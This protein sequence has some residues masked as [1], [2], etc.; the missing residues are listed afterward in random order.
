[1]AK[2]S[3]KI[4]EVVKKY[5]KNAKDTGKTDVQIAILT[6]KI[7]ELSGHVQSHLKDHHSRKGL[8]GM[9]TRRRRLLKYLQ[10]RDVE[11]YRVLIKELDIRR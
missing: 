6:E 5:G 7:N 9:V 2:Q 3:E 1:L 10:D 11:R 8:L 4:K